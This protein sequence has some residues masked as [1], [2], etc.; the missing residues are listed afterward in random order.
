MKI[1]NLME[2]SLE[3]YVVE[4]NLISAPLIGSKR[5]LVDTAYTNAATY[6]ADRFSDPYGVMFDDLERRQLNATLNR[7]PTVGKALEVGCGT[8]RFLPMVRERGHF[9]CGVD[10]SAPMLEAAARRLDALGGVE[11]RQAEGVAL[12]FPQHTFDFVYSIRTLNQVESRGYA[13]RMLDEAMRVLKPGGLMMVEFMNRWG[14]SPR[15]VML[16]YRDIRRF[17]ARYPHAH[18]LCFRGI[19]IFSFTAMRYVPLPLLP[20]YALCDRAVSR[21]FPVLA[22]RCYATIRRDAARSKDV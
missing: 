16:S 9:V 3:D 20:V 8:G 14:L 19:L 11:L 15:G 12:P 13:L 18:M 5:C 17:V 2:Q 4:D 22:T 1:V 6:D 10:P 21:V 7:I